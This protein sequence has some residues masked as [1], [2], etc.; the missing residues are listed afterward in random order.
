M[1]E[2]FMIVQN[3]KNVPNWDSPGVHVESCWQELEQCYDNAFDAVKK[4]NTLQF[5]E[6]YIVIKYY[7]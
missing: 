3:F 2:K 5:S 7:E 6:H 1:R 4:K